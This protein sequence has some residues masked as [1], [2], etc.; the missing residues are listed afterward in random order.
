MEEFEKVERLVEKAHVSYEDAKKALEISGGDMLDAMIYLEKEGK[1]KAPEHS[2]YNTGSSSN[3][4]YENVADAVNRSEGSKCKSFFRSLG[5]VCGKII[6][7]LSENS[8]SVKKND[9][10]ILKLPLWIVIILLMIAWEILA[11]I[12]LVSLFVGCRY[13]IIGKDDASG[14]NGIFDQA[15]NL[16][17]KAKEKFTEQTENKPEAGTDNIQA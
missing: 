3:G 4:R 15:A 2:S 12:M 6:R 11:V 14:V 17:G 8:L 9:E 13:Q 7:F 10:Q 1:A 5:E 16:A